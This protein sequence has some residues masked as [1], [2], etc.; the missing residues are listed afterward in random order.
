M[1]ASTLRHSRP[2]LAW[3]RSAKNV[4]GWSLRKVDGR[5]TLRI[6]SPHLEA[7]R[8]PCPPAPDQ[9][10]RQRARPTPGTVVGST[11]RRL[12]KMSSLSWAST[13][14]ASRRWRPSALVGL[15][16]KR[17]S[18]SRRQCAGMRLDGGIGEI[19]RRPPMSQARCRNGLN[20]RANTVSPAS[21]AHCASR[22][23]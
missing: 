2:P 11:S 21:M 17:R 22:V 15:R 8:I 3:P 18:S 1:V 5:A 9:F 7:S 13:M 16:L 14:M 20:S 6:A 19:G 23:K 12:R 10:D 4:A